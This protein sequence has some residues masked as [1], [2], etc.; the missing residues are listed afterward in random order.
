LPPNFS[1]LVEFLI[2]GFGSCGLTCGTFPNR[3]SGYGLHSINFLSPSHSHSH[4]NKK[5]V[6]LISLCC[7]NSS[8]D[9]NNLISYGNAPPS[10]H[11]NQLKKDNWNS[12]K[13]LVYFLDLKK[14]LHII[15]IKKNWRLFSW[16]TSQA[17][18]INLEH[19]SRKRALF[20]RETFFFLPNIHST[21]KSF[22][23]KVCTKWIQ[24]WVVFSQQKKE[25]E[26][27]V[28]KTRVGEW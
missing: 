5:D 3:N 22:L 24:K 21:Q 13:I 9:Q 23:N 4:T 27:K 10:H 8:K 16:L 19:L 17:S 28:T 1:S 6:L 15:C 14:L 26:R 11:E 2:C 12:L 7:S 20:W 25:R 18:R